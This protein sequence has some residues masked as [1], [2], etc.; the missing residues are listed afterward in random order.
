MG[1]ASRL[2][3]RTP[4]EEAALGRL[5]G[6]AETGAAAPLPVADVDGVGFD[7]IA[8]ASYES[9]TA[10]AGRRRSDDD[11]A[12]FVPGAAPRDERPETAGPRRGQFAPTRRLSPHG[13]LAMVDDHHVLSAPFAALCQIEVVFEKAPEQRFRGTGFRIGE[14]LALT[15]AHCLQRPD[16]GRALRMNLYLNNGADQPLRPFGIRVSREWRRAMEQGATP[17]ARDDYGVVLL[18][19]NGG[20]DGVA[21]DAFPYIPIQAVDRRW[22]AAREAARYRL[23][24]FPGDGARQGLPDYMLQQA[25]DFALP[26]FPRPVAALMERDGGRGAAARFKR[27]CIRHRIASVP[28]FAGAPMLAA[29]PNIRTNSVYEA[30]VGLHLGGADG[31]GVARIIDDELKRRLVRWAQEARRAAAALG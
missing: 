11:G 22:F 10:E 21:D 16:L 25:A 12:A 17:L 5:E 8:A 27:H 23:A 30:A 31:I 14:H 18:A 4:P 9:A 3:G 28:G 7:A 15:A 1:L 13:G 26:I 19:P 20:E 6:F 29:I 2:T 24:G